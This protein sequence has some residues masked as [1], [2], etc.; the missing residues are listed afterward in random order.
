VRD[1]VERRAVECQ[2]GGHAAE[3]ADGFVLARGERA[4]L[5]SRQLESRLGMVLATKFLKRD[6]L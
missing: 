1:Q 6:A 5:M 4:E 2:R 3:L